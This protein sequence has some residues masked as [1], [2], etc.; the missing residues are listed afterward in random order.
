MRPFASSTEKILFLMRSIPSPG[1]GVRIARNDR[2][3][4]VPEP[5]GPLQHGGESVRLLSMPPERP[6][7]RRDF[8]RQGAL[9]TTAL[10]AGLPEAVAFL[11]PRAAEASVMG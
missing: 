6:M 11:H 9:L 5:P 3:P 8:L 2:V 1:Q 10:A 4:T 7:S